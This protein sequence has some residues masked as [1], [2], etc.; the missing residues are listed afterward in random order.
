[1]L[2]E[3]LSSRLIE[4]AVNNLASLLLGALISA[5]FILVRLRVDDQVRDALE[6]LNRIDS[7]LNGGDHHANR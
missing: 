7:K 3:A 1:M 4:L 2:P 6:L 5:W